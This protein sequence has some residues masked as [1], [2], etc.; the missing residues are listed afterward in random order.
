MRVIIGGISHE[1]STFTPVETTWESYYERFYFHGTEMLS[2]FRDTNTPIG[3]FIAGCEAQGIE[4]IPT[5]FA[6]AH[7]SGPTPRPIFDHIVGE[8]VEGVEA[9]GAIDGVLLD[10]HGSM[11]VGDLDAPDGLHDPEAYLLQTIRNVVGT[12]MPILAQLDIHANVSPE[13]VE[14]ADVLI[15]RETYPEID[16]AERGRECVDVLVQMKR[17]GIKPTMALHQIPMIWGMHQ[18]TDHAPMREAIA[19]LHVLEAT[20]GVICASIAVC[21]FMADVLNMGASVYVVTNNDPALAQKLADELGEWCYARRA[22]WH[23][24][25]P[26]TKEALAQA[27]AAGKYPIVLADTRDNTGGGSPGDSTEMLRVFIE[28]GLEEACLLYMVDREVVG[29][30]HAA[31]VGATLTMLVGGKSSPLQGEPV[32]MTFEVM[33]LSDGRFYYEGPMYHGLEGKMGLSAYIRQGGLHVIL[34]SVGE[35]PYDTAF[36]KSM[37]LDPQEMRY[38]GLKSTAHFRAGYEAWAGYVQL[39]S[40]PSVHNLGNLPFKRLKWRVYPL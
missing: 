5:V 1:T 23:Y 4:M 20:P 31:G 3:G 38:I 36:A 7:P 27:E 17:D 16:M 39:V 35:Q 9:A 34:V 15:G 6:E 2:F 21:Y 40:E 12:D 32:E 14:A 33:A 18:V 25:L 10:L 19:K 37:G 29:A 22:D 30:C 8:I 13:M 11:V 24:E 26:S 28:A